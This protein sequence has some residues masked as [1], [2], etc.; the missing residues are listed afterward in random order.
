MIKVME[1]NFN[2]GSRKLEVQDLEKAIM[3]K[4]HA[5]VTKDFVAATSFILSK[6]IGAKSKGRGKAA[7]ASVKLDPL[8][9]TKKFECGQWCS[10]L[11]YYNVTE[12]DRNTITVKNSWGNEL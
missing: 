7:K 6:T 3:T 10:S 12:I 11:A 4:S 5:E 8:L 9:D 1:D 2:S